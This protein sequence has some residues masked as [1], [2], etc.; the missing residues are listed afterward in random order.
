MLLSRIM[1]ASGLSLIAIGVV[2]AIAV[3]PLL[4][5]VAL[6]GVVDLVLARVFRSGRFG[7]ET[8]GGGSEGE[9]SANPY[10]RED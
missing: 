10:A 3:D 2:L 7:V 8:A 1:F 5:L 4:G 6:A 9:P